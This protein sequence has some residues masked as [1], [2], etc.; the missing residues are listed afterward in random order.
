MVH[1]CEHPNLWFFL[2]SLHTVFW[3]KRK[4]TYP[5]LLRTIIKGGNDIPVKCCRFNNRD[6]MNYPHRWESPGNYPY[7]EKYVNLPLCLENY[8]IFS[9]PPIFTTILY[10]YPLIYITYLE[11]PSGNIISNDHGIFIQI[12][13]HWYDPIFKNIN[14]T[15][16]F[17]SM[18]MALFFSL[19]SCPQYI[20][21]YIIIYKIGFYFCWYQ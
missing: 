13:M 11:E 15:V 14:E 9:L 18:N 12:Y 7:F 6:Y 21:N 17:S 10:T 2:G 3:D 16:V 19:F 5:F 20:K 8:A 1:C 4:G